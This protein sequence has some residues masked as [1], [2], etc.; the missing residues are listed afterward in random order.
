MTASVCV[1][2]GGPNTQERVDIGRTHCTKDQCVAAW[3]RGRIHDA[4]LT[5]V[6]VHK[7]GPMWIKVHDVPA[8]SMRRDGGGGSK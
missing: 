4:G 1:T 3:R 5:L 6:N 2:C 7:Q 8:N